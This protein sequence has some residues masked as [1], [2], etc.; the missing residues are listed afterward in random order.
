M[1]TKR[2]V[3]LC[4]YQNLVNYKKPTSFQLK[5]SYPLPPP[6]TVIGMVPYACGYSEYEPM[7]V[8]IQANFNSLIISSLFLN[9][10]LIKPTFVFSETS[11]SK[12]NT[13]FIASILIVL[14]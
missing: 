8:S 6:S 12:F 11:L 5:E 2:A 3:R 9:I 4:L 7:V 10:P 1:S 14:L 13:L